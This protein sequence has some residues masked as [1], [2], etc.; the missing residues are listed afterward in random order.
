MAE[1]AQEVVGTVAVGWQMAE[2]AMAMAATEAVGTVNR[3]GAASTR[4]Q[5]A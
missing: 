4:V 1:E 3:A 5:C 2:E